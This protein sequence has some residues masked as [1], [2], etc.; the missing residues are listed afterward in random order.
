MAARHDSPRAA[1]SPPD[2]PRWG[3]VTLDAL[4][5][6][7][8]AAFA[9]QRSFKLLSATGVGPRGQEDRSVTKQQVDQLPGGECGVLP[10]MMR[11]RIR[12]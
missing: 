4:D 2:V 12:D 7:L 9:S 11:R 6:E 8:R 10:E 3:E 1:R 5:A